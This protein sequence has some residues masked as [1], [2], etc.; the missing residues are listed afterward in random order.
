MATLVARLSR[1]V[2]VKEQRKHHLTAAFQLS[3]SLVHLR[4]V[5]IQV[6]RLS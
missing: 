5:G 1:F 3:P 6:F 2:T 4:A